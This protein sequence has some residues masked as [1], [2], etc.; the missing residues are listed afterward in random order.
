MDYFFT[1]EEET[2]RDTVKDFLKE[3]LP[4]DWHGVYPDAYFMDEY[5]SFIRSFTSQMA[6]KGWLTAAWPKEYGGQ[7]L[8]VM[9]QAV[10]NEELS[11]QSAPFRDM[12]TGVNLVGPTVMVHGSEEQKQEWLPPIATGEHVYCQ[13]FSEPGSGSD[14]ASL[15]TVAQRDGDE[16]VINGSKIWTSGAHR[17]SHCILLTRTDQ[18]APK[19]RGISMF[20]LPMDTPGIT[21]RPIHNPLNVHYF[22]QVFFDNV[23]VSRDR[24]VG[25]ENRGW[26]AATT[27]LDFE[28]S[29]VGRFATTQRLLDELARLAREVP[30][31]DG[32]V[33]DDPIYKHALAD[34][35]IANHAGRTIA[36]RVAW[37]QSQGLIPNQEASASKLMGSEIAQRAAQVGM[38]LFGLMGQIDRGPRYAL[39]EGKVMAHYVNTVAATIR[40]GTSEVQRNIIATRGLGLPRA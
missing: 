7:A 22:N 11:Y 23:R 26:Y 32:T 28:R 4:E 21:V 8:P 17:S 31:R 20:L 15:Q 2:F 18:D 1:P 40:G 6:D 13:G 30:G 37:M 19:H 29:G 39:L 3:A 10:L 33:L 12:S 9:R 25:E 14:L 34:V 36:Y 38:R 27:T 24:M 35:V 16:Y 5:W